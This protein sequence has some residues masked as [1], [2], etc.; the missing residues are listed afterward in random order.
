VLV[1]LARKNVT[2]SEVYVGGIV[3]QPGSAWFAERLKDAGLSAP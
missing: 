3:D 2:S 1:T